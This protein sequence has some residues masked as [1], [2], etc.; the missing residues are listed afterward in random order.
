MSSLYHKYSGVRGIVC[1]M[2][3]LVVSPKVKQYPYITQKTK[4]L[5]ESLA[6][7]TLVAE[8]H[9]FKGIVLV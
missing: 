4:V 9:P 6:R 1:E 8:Q 5:G 7:C 3:G 2:S